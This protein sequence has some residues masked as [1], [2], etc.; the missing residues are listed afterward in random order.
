MDHGLPKQW[1]PLLHSTN[2]DG[3]G[4][5]I[6]TPRREYLPPKA[7]GKSV[8]GPRYN[9]TGAPR[10]SE[11]YAHVDFMNVV[12]TVTVGPEVVV[13]IEV[14]NAGKRGAEKQAGHRQRASV[15]LLRDP[16]FEPEHV[17][18]AAFP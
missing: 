5:R 18:D 17:T 6:L 11:L 9:Q 10:R 7:L 14:T 2:I 1:A 4:Q 8:H 16:R 15:I 12:M 3:V 13:G